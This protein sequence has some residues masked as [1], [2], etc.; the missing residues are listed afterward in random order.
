VVPLVSKSLPVGVLSE[1]VYEEGQV[2]IEP[3]DILLAYTDGLVEIGA[4][5][6]GLQELTAELEGTEPAEDRVGRLVN[7]VLGQQE[8]DV[9]VVLLQRTGLRPGRPGAAQA[10]A[11][12]HPPRP[13]GEARLA[14]TCSRGR[15]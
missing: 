8:D 10:S 13:A 4:Q 1:A 11:R 9:T 12:R 3:G 6:I 14:P 15:P 7:R 5:T 2:T